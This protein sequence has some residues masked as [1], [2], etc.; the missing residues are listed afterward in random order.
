MCRVHIATIS[1]SALYWSDK[2]DVKIQTKL[3]KN[4]SAL[5]CCHL[6]NCI[7]YQQQKCVRTSIRQFLWRELDVEWNNRFFNHPNG[8][9]LYCRE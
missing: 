5:P 7:V 3:G 4:I 9:A 6:V 2:L 8:I 1:D